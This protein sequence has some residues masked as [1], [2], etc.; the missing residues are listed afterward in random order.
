MSS[1]SSSN[2]LTT[3]SDLIKHLIFLGQLGSTETAL[4]HQ[5]VAEKM[6]SDITATK[7]V[8]TLMQEGPQ[9]PGYLAKRLHLTTG[10]VTAVIDRLEKSGAVKRTKDPKDRRKIIVKVVPEKIKKH[11]AFYSSMS[12]ASKK[13]WQGYTVNELEFL[14][15]YEQKIIEMTKNEIAKLNDI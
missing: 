14:V 2:I 13:F 7:A 8:S 6:G 11:G 3:K 10:A 1:E 15:D 12:D 9:T 5:K 4:F